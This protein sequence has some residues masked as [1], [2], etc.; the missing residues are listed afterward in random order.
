MSVDLHKQSHILFFVVFLPLLS[1]GIGWLFAQLIPD[2]PFWVETISPLAAYGLLFNFFDKVA[3]R[4]PVFRWLGIVCVPDL[5]GRWLG[6]QVS[7][8]KSENGKHITSRVIMEVEQTF[9]QIKAQTYYAKW[10]TSIT[11]AQF[12]DIQQ[13]PTFL[14]LFDAEPS[15]LYDG[16]ATI[17]KGVTK[18]IQKPDGTLEGSYFNANGRHGELHFK[19]TRYTLYR[20]FEAIGGQ[21]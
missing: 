13:V 2:A 10:H 11:A 5:R 16:D 20:T 21:K 17:H 6:E 19:R 12:V 4:W 15:A 14:I 18:L 9:S 8:Y 1:F 7:S 3:W